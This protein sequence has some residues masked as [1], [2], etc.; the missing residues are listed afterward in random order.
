MA[1]TVA[2]QAVDLINQVGV[3]DVIVPFLLGF[4]I[5]FSMLEKTKI[6]G[7]NKQVNLIISFCVGIVA[8]LSF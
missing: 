2:G 4:A 3:F 5:T 8:A 1:Y 7:G 6:F